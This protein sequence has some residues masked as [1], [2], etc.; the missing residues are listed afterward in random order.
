MVVTR[1]SGM[2]LGV[3]TQLW[4]D[5]DEWEV[6]ALDLRPNLAFGN[7]DHALM[8][9]LRQV[10]DVILVHDEGAVERRWS[11]YGYSSVIGCDVVT[12]RGMM[13]GKIRDF[14]FDPEVGGGS[15]V[16]IPLP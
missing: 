15:C 9:S 1:T 7:V 10:G 6:V 12:E 2:R 16:V 8:S 11:S 4:V 13:L 14:E 5:T 3:A